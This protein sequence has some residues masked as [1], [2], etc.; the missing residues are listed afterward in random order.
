MFLI[1]DRNDSA[2][3]ILKDLIP[4][5]A[6]TIPNTSLFSSPEQQDGQIFVHYL[7][8]DSGIIVT[9]GECKD[10]C[11]EVIGVEKAKSMWVQ[12]WDDGKCLV[13]DPFDWTGWQCWEPNLNLCCRCIT[14]AYEY[15][16]RVVSGAWMNFLGNPVQ[17]VDHVSRVDPNIVSGVS[18]IAD[19]IDREIVKDKVRC[20]RQDQAYNPDFDF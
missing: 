5:F 3:E 4:S 13:L 9:Q 17:L 15:H 12:H 7:G 1:V 10:K 14:L 2:V 20:P 18:H 6:A 19:Y 16:C 8:S 11:L